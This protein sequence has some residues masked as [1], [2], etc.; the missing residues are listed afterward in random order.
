MSDTLITNLVTFIVA[1]I[2]IMSIIVKLNSTYQEKDI[3]TYNLKQ[4]LN[5]MGCI[6]NKSIKNA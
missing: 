4:T 2:P 3:I 6:S 5:K 1:M